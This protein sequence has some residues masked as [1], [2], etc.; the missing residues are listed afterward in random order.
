MFFIPAII[1]VGQAI[2]LYEMGKSKGYENGK[3]DGKKEGYSRASRK[4]GEKFNLQVES[5][6]K[7][8][9]KV[10]LEKEEYDFLLLE[11]EKKIM[12]LEGKS[13]DLTVEEY[14][15]LSGTKREYEILKSSREACSNESELY[16]S[17]ES[18]FNKAESGNPD[19]QYYLGIIY[20]SRGNSTTNDIE[21]ALYWLEKAAEQGHIGSQYM[22]GLFY[23]TG[24]LG[25]NDFN[26]SLKWLERSANQGHMVSQL[27]LGSIYSSTDYHKSFKWHLKAAR[28]GLMDAQYYVGVYYETGSGVE[29]NKENALYWLEKAAEQGHIDAQNLF[30]TLIEIENTDSKIFD[31]EY[32]KN[33]AKQGDLEAQSILGTAYYLGNGVEKDFKKARYWFM[34]AAKQGSEDAQGLLGTIYY[35]GQGTEKDYDSALYWLEKAANQGHEESRSFLKKTDLLESRESHNL[36]IE[37]TAEPPRKTTNLSSYDKDSILKLA[38]KTKLS[39][40]D[41]LKYYKANGKDYIQTLLFIEKNIKK[42]NFTLSQALDETFG[43]YLNSKE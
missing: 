38:K 40:S 3:F 42:S 13:A 31:I 24:E 39:K 18:I 2:I 4:Y 23:F 22:V 26:K 36:C 1:A 16:M 10:A 32:C 17:E 20:Y 37:T 5:F 28:Q 12:E 35:Y 11:H 41:V 8:K 30:N 25:I 43:I 21:K 7:F 14:D 34:K 33:M 9:N 15:E 6:E 29:K 27:L 19:F